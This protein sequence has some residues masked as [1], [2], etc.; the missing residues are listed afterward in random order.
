MHS[1]LFA[2]AS[3]ALLSLGAAAVARAQTSAI[4][5]IHTGFAHAWQ[6]APGHG[7]HQGP[8]AHRGTAWVLGYWEGWEGRK[9]REARS[10]SP[11][12]VQGQW[13]KARHGHPHRETRWVKDH[14][15]WDRDGDGAPNRHDRH[16][17]DPRSG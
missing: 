16:P 7:Q 6:T 14:G 15:R 17:A 9:R 10:H 1:L 13:V 5:A 2:A 3:I 4:V 8:P 12:W 11:V